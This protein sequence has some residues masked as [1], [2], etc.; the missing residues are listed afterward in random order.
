ADEAHI[1]FPQRSDEGLFGRVL[2]TNTPIQWSAWQMPLA[3]LGVK[4]EH[5]PFF[6]RSGTHSIM[7]AP[8]QTRE[9][10]LG[11]IAVWR[12]SNPAAFQPEDL[13]LLQELAG[14]AANSIDHARLYREARD[15]EEQYRRLF[16]AIPEAAWV[17]DI[18][19]L[20]FLAANS[21]AVARYGYTHDEFM[22][23]T[24]AD[25]RLPE[26]WDDM[27]R[28]VAEI[29]KEG[30]HSVSIRQVCK[31][32][33][34]I[35]ADLMSHPIRFAGRRAQLVIAT[36]V[37]ERRRA[38]EQLRAAEERYRMLVNRMPG[39]VYLQQ[40]G[41]QPGIRYISPSV[42]T[43]LGYT[44]E[45]CMADPQHWIKVL[46]PDDR[47]RVVREHAAATAEGRRMVAEY[48]FIAQDGRSVWVHDEL[49]PIYDD[50]GVA[51]TW[52]GVI[53]DIT[54]QRLAEEALERN[55][56]RFASLVHNVTDI[57]GVMRADGTLS[58]ISPAVERV[59]GYSV[60]QRDILS[61]DTI[62]HPDDR[63]MFRS[64]VRDIATEPRATR[65]VHLRMLHSGGAWRTLEARL[66]NLLDDA[67]VEGIVVIGNDITERQE[68]EA[69][70]ARQAFYDSLTGLPN[71][72]LFLD[73]LHH[74]MQRGERAASPFAVL[75][76]DVDNF[77]VVN[78]SL[79]HAIGDDLLLA[80][81]RR[82]ESLVRP[83]DTVARFGG[84]EFT[85]L[86]D[87]VHDPRLAETVAERILNAL[88]APFEIAGRALPVSV[89]IGIVSAAGVHDGPDVLLRNADIALYR[90]KA[91]GKA[92]YAV[93]DNGMHAQALSRLQLEVDLRQA[94][95]RAELEVHY[96][97]IVSLH[98][99]Q[100]RAYEALLRWH[101]PER[102]LVGPGEF[103][104]MAEETGLIVPLGNW[105]LRTAAQQLR[106][107]RDERSVP[108]KL[109][110]TVNLAARQ[111]ALSNL[112]DNVRDILE[113]SGI[114]PHLLT[115]EVSE[116]AMMG[117]I[118]ATI[119]TLDGL[120]SLGVRLAIDD[121]GAGYS[122]LAHLKRFPVHDLKVD[123]A[124]VVGLGSDERDTL[125][126]G[127]MISIAHALQLRVIAEGVETHTQHK[128][129]LA[130]GCDSGQ[131]F[132]Y[133]RP[134]P[135]AEWQMPAS[136][137]R[138]AVAYT[139]RAR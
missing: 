69:R 83:G 46:H 55:E 79:G 5:L 36:D 95:E 133:G 11:V 135:A 107:W 86:L 130:L 103:L 67:S 20:R 113:H 60:E 81:A 8:L 122:S 48:R 138:R 53:I 104:S 50:D 14:L 45:A 127:G 93:F 80:L 124:F 97:P 68:F 71:R 105:V 128:Q 117:D 12:D 6:Q 59:L 27:N 70:L 116:T 94:I 115:L 10:A 22:Q 21:T 25:L 126:V 62:V 118:D 30:P 82:L 49:I 58:Y 139:R 101:R 109:G 65:R 132:F 74:A 31:D 43:M 77:K 84:D 78:D 19:S 106:Q 123:R 66:T 17:F 120:R 54:E 99:R 13:D 34:I 131:G 91:R 4:P 2:A 18:E 9:C 51:R 52:H 73:R 29:P 1:L 24:I 26:D 134:R 57:V 28:L 119:A 23:L 44:P 47:E 39:V 56:R 114:P 96:Q 90:A 87:N 85:L 121:F 112:V 37:T 111:F 41:E 35:Q 38:E 100:P 7:V 89:S 33:T 92:G 61:F 137:S 108:E 98:T 136:V 16:E 3:D 15:A 129:L 76:L 102:G 42:E 40:F 125:M 32:G 72:A 110:I 88:R 75:F 63:E 64:V